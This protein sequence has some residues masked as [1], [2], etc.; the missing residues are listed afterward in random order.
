M[1]REKALSFSSAVIGRRC[2]ANVIMVTSERESIWPAKNVSRVSELSPFTTDLS[3][4]NTLLLVT[5]FSL[6]LVVLDSI[7]DSVL[8]FKRRAS[9][10]LLLPI[11]DENVERNISQKSQKTM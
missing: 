6:L 8:L 5:L 11:F 1:H 3:A 2:V 10:Y 7:Y 4:C 9:T